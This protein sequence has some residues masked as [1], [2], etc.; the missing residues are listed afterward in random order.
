[1]GDVS[2]SLGHFGEHV[3]ELLYRV[4]EHPFGT[5][6]VKEPPSAEWDE[7]FRELSMQAPP[8]DDFVNDSLA[9]RLQHFAEWLQDTA[10]P[11]LQNI[12]NDTVI[13]TSIKAQ[14]KDLVDAG[15]PL[16]EARKIVADVMNIEIDWV[17]I[18]Q[19]PHPGS[20]LANVGGVTQASNL[21]QGLSQ[22]IQAVVPGI[23]PQEII[24]SID[25]T[26]VDV[27]LPEIRLGDVVPVSYTHL[28]L[29][30]TPYV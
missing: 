16:D 17:K 24:K 27:S 11:Y 28:T 8:L 20:G 22:G 29:P 9:T 30:T 5:N 10:M 6:F 23:D 1:M 4:F 3:K 19:T 13:A 12:Q 26:G 18:A 21:M 14:V 15:V 25:F 7:L 2:G